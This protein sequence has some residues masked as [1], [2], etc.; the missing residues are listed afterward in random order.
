[1]N[2]YLASKMSSFYFANL[3][4]TQLLLAIRALNLKILH[5]NLLRPE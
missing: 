5:G 3:G 2:S 1:M 4:N